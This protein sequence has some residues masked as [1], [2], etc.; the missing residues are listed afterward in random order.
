M[1]V[2]AGVVPPFAFAIL[3]AGLAAAQTPAPSSASAGPTRGYV[4]AIAQS[5][6]GNITSQS[7]G[8]EFG[9]TVAND[10]QVFAEVGQIRNVATA[11]IGASA[12]QIAA[13]LRDVQSAAVTYTVKQPVTLGIGGVRYLIPAG[14]TNVRPYV[15][16]GVGVARV[17]N[18]VKYQFGGADASGTIAQFVT[19]GSDLS[20]TSTHAMLATG[21]GVA[22]PAWR[23]LIIDLQYRF[24]RIFADPSG[25]NTNRLGVGIGVRF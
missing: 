15:L 1:R 8:G 14:S 7:Y 17:S 12:E 9:T 2:L 10:V 23:R 6:F 5:A 25:I 4:E 16:A 24:G 22:I 19:L 3:L 13:V 18:D 21:A 20:G 11:A